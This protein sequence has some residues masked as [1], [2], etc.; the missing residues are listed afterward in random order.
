MMRALP[1]RI[2]SLTV[3]RI[4][5]AVVAWPAIS[6]SAVTAPPAAGF[7]A[8]PRV[9]DLPRSMADGTYWPP[10]PGLTAQVTIGLRC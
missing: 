7:A 1:K 2:L 10:E 9:P 3:T 5:V 8:G 6:A 4:A